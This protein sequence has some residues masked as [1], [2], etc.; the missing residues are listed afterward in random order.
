MTHPF[1][2]LLGATGFDLKQIPNPENL[3][4]GHCR[5][6]SFF[7]TYVDRERFHVKG[8]AKSA[9][10]NFVKNSLHALLVNDEI[11][12]IEIETLLNH[13]AD[14]DPMIL[15]QLNPILW[16]KW[17]KAAWDKLNFYKFFKRRS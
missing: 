10:G 3:S 7:A 12:L 6:L 2:K 11:D 16:K 17:A 4:T 9:T 1:L 15:Q 8:N 14:L 5:L 13:V